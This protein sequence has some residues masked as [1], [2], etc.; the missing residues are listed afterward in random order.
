MQGGRRKR[1]TTSHL[2]QPSGHGR[3][4]LN[5][6][7]VTVREVLVCGGP[8]AE[9]REGGSWKLKNEEEEKERSESRFS[10]L[11]ACVYCVCVCDHVV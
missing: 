8:W 2:P 4:P 11:L 10:H 3:I 6:S 9:Q 1:T 5:P 7:K